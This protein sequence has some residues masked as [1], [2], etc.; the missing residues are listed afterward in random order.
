MNSNIKLLV[1]GFRAIHSAEVV[2]DGITLVAG[3]N[4]SG[5]STISKLTYYLFKTIQNYERLVREKLDQKLS[6]VFT[7]AEIIQNEI[8]T[9]VKTRNLRSEL[10]RDILELRR[11][12]TSGNS[13]DTEENRLLSFLDQLE[14]TYSNYILNINPLSENSFGPIHINPRQVRLR[15]IM[16]EIIGETYSGDDLGLAF[17]KIKNFVKSRFAEAK[18]KIQSRPNGLFLEEL[19]DI[20][21]DS[22]LPN[23]FEV[24]EFES[25]IASLSS[26][27]LS[28]PFSIQNCIYIDTPMMIAVEDSNYPHWD[29]LTRLLQ[30]GS[31]KSKNALL[32]II[33]HQII[34]GEADYEDDFFSYDD[35]SFKRDD[36]A[37]F[38]L[39]DVATGIKSFSIL[40]LLLKNGHLTNKTLLI[41]DEPESHL[42]PQWIIEYARIIVLLNKIV[43]VKFLLASHNPDMVS[44]IKYISEKEDII[45]AVN[46]YIAEKV[47]ES[48]VYNYRSLGQNI[49]PIFSSF[50]IAFDRMSLYGI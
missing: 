43:G 21:T 4:G 39:L 28:I 42:H 31:Q 14:K 34:R 8:L 23:K 16:N 25:V 1:E 9:E 24:R 29:D 33:S 22:K 20:F 19:A 47:G 40:Q 10:R 46:F 26:S 12:L 2:I 3:E 48:F 35:F 45:S 11:N 17:K 6:E 30:S 7:F 27:N 5:K 15:R 49:D 32:D 50:N 44:A 36:G 41:I 37:I 38:S 18:N 13:L